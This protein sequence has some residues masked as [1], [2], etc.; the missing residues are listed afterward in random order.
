MDINAC[1]LHTGSAMALIYGRINDNT[2]HILGRW[3]SDAMLRYF[4]LQAKPLMRQFAVTMFNHGSYFFLPT[5]TIS[6]D[7]HYQLHRIPPTHPPTTT[8]TVLTLGS[9]L[10]TLHSLAFGLMQNAVFGH[11]HNCTPVWAQCAQNQHAAQGGGGNGTS[12]IPFTQSPNFTPH[13]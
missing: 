1:S 9:Q 12:K 5:D 3:H 7:D 11:H 6:S 13:S 8:T 2:I 4:H 10:P